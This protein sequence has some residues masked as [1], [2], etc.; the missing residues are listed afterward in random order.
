MRLDSLLAL[1]R[2]GAATYARHLLGR[3]LE[4]SWNVNFEVG[5]RFWRHQFS[6]AL[7]QPDIRKGRR[8]FDSLQ[9]ETDD[10]YVVSS[11]VT[12]EP[13]GRWYLPKTRLTDAALLYLHGGGYAFHGAASRRMAAMLAHRSG[14]KL[15]ALDYRLTPEHSHPAQ[16]DDAVAA[17]RYVIERTAPE[18]IVVVGDSAGG[19]MALMLLQSLKDRNLPQPCL[20][21]GLCP[22][23]DVGDRGESLHENDR[24]DLVQGWMAL[25]FGEWLDPE[26]KYG[27]SAL[28]PISY[29]YKGLAPIYLQAGGREI[30]HDMIRDFATKQS[31]LGADILLDV[32]PDMPHDFQLFD[33]VKPSA[34]QAIARIRAAIGHFVDRNG[35]FERGPN[36][37]VT[38]GCF[39]ID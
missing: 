12:G 20:C 13:K 29:E 16:A 5:V 22:W 23:T 6:V 32:W 2:I 15:F 33:T 10:V 34:G 38:N 4:P 17:W 3:R 9:T 39:L 37:T 24:Y 28:S 35:T 26:R 1:N 18:K 11:E 8:L 14:A 30:L 27:R 31:E 21:I 19:H 36:T 7:R 25:R